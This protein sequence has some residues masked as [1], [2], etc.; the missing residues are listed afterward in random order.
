MLVLTS[1]LVNGAE[2]SLDASFIDTEL[3]YSIG[4]QTLAQLETG[5][6]GIFALQPDRSGL[7]LSRDKNDD[8]TTV[9]V[10]PV[11]FA[12]VYSELLGDAGTIT[13]TSGVAELAVDEYAWLL[14]SGGI[15][16]SQYGVTDTP[17]GSVSGLLRFDTLHNLTVSAEVDDSTWWGS[18]RSSSVDEIEIEAGATATMDAGDYLAFLQRQNLRARALSRFWGN[19]AQAVEVSDD[20]IVSGYEVADDAALEDLTVDEAVVYT[21]ADNYTPHSPAGPSSPY[22]TRRGAVRGRGQRRG[23]RSPCLTHRRGRDRCSALAVAQAK[24]VSG[25]R[26]DGPRARST[27]RTTR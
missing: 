25:H 5:E 13:V 2:S 24:T 21:A 14:A 23:Q 17:S 7:F 15:T 16:E 26:V 20:T 9:D 12:P 6:A 19:I 18:G 11:A 27:S 4:Q 8:T 1:K 22:R 10:T 3:G